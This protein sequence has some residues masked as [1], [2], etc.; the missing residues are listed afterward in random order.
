MLEQAG[1]LLRST[2]R[3]EDIVCR[4]GGEE[5]L[6]IM[7]EAALESAIRRANFLKDQFGAMSIDHNGAAI[8][9]ITISVGVASTESAGYSREELMRA[10]DQC[11]YLAKSQGRNRVCANSPESVAVPS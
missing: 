5:F 7:A 11:L 10:A 8:E 4:L 9:A 3:A 6:V 2:V 1:A